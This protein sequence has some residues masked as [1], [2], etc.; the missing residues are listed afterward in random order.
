MLRSKFHVSFT[1]T[2]PDDAA[3]PSMQE[4]ILDLRLRNRVH[5]M[6]DVSEA[7]VATSDMP[8]KCPD[9][10]SEECVHMIEFTVAKVEHGT[11]TLGRTLWTTKHIYCCMHQRIGQKADQ[12]KH[13]EWQ[14][15]VTPR[16]ALSCD[17]RSSLSSS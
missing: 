1:S 12:N 14:H 16:L 9:T 5:G 3:R 11:K 10:A 17:V 6:S 15:N 13:S 8:T 4:F 2:T 7:C